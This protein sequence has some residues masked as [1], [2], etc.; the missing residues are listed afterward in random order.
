VSEQVIRHRG[1]GRDKNSQ[2]S[3]GSNVPLTAMQVAPRGGAETVERTR[4][5]ETV[6]CTVY[7]PLDT[8]IKNSDEI[9]VRSER[10]S[11][12]VNEWRSGGLGGLEVLCTRGQG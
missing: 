4:D 10:F 9:T 7:F 2:W 11:I 8:D 3:P 6:A 12:I 5:G 1:G